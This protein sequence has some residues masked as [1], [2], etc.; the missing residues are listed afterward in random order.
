MFS[1][2]SVCPVGGW[3]GRCM[4]K[5]GACM[6]KE[7]HAWCVHGGMHGAVTSVALG[8]RG[9]GGEACMAGAHAWQGHGWWGGG[10]GACVAGETATAADGTYPTGMHSCNIRSSLTN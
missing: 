2:A 8:M 1:Q 9:G 4:V 7:G 6:A 10:K 3:V 5:G